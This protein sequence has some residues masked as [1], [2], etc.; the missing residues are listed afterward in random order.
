M[1][2][3][4]K[5]FLCAILVFLSGLSLWAMDFGLL[6]DQD[7]GFGGLGTDTQFDYTGILIPRF[8]AL[9]GETGDFTLSAGFRADYQGEAWALFPELLRT[10]LTLR[11]GSGEL[12]AGRMQYS[13]P[14]GF[15]AEGLFDGARYSHD[16]GIGSF[17]VGA[18][19]TGLL[20]KNRIN[21]TMTGA[22]LESSYVALDYGDFVNTYFAPRRL[23]SA[24]GWEHPGLG[25]LV[26]ADAA[27][28]GQFDLSGKEELHSQY[29]ALKFTLPYRDFV[30]D[31]GGS[32]E[33]TELKE[34]LGIA[35]AGELGAAWAPPL[36]FD[37]QL[38]FL[39]RFSSG[40]VEDGSVVAFLPVT[41][42]SQGEILKAKL[43][44]LSMLSLEYTARIFRSF[45]A[46]LSSSYFIR[47]DLGTYTAGYGADGYF[48]GNEFYGRLIWSPLS[49]IMMKAGGGV[50]LPSLGN[51]APDADPLWR[52]ELNVIISLF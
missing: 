35:M 32:F 39:G 26:R 10:E 6:L 11:F 38:A 28:L 43:S 15:I 9:I 27:L 17:S 24:L 40:V 8:S 3:F 18:W 50:F 29:L 34:E 1:K 13:D 7:A 44:G 48:L 52:V 16:T 49:D 33:L 2:K 47:S 14:L 22:E 19:Y 37:S 41:T 12:K 36:S 21:I 31:L 4:L 20:Y 46:G 23:L 5:P 42:S 51:A 30:F 45:S 25:D